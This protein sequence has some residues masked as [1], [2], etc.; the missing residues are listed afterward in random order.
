MNADPDAVESLASGPSVLLAEN[1]AATAMLVRTLLTRWGFAV[2]A[3]PCDTAALRQLAVQ[4]FDLAIVGATGSDASVVAAACIS[5][6]VPVVALVTEGFRLGGAAVDLPLPF[7]AASLRHAV[8]RCL[9]HANADLDAAAIGLLWERPDNPIYHRIARVFIGEIGIRLA[10]I[11]EAMAAGDLKRMETEA[12]SIKGAGGNV[13]A[14][15][16]RDAAA[17]L[18][19]AA[20]RGDTQSLPVLIDALRVAA[21]RGIVALRRLFASDTG[22]P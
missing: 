20:S 3:T 17:L 4:S 22:R 9:S 5:S 14:H 6:C 16:V 15:A 18:E 12:H 13:A 11:A 1:S 8:D 19:A 7:N 21:D 10:S 2:T